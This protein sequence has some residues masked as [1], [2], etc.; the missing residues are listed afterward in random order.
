MANALPDALHENDIKLLKDMGANFIR[1]SHYP[2]DPAVLEAC[3]RLGI[4][5]SE[6]IP[7]VNRITQSAAFTANCENMQREMIRQNFNHPSI[8]I[9]AYMNE[10]LLQPRYR[11]DSPEQQKYF[12]DVAKLAKTLDSL[13]RSVKTRHAIR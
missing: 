7:V 2:Q 13:T 1:I 5:A 8:I 11:R 4:L 6:E 12:G 3:D 10:V 9:W